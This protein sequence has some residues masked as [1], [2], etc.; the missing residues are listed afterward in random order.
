MGTVAA[1]DRHLPSL[2]RPPFV[3][4]LTVTFA[5]FVRPLNGTVMEVPFAVP[6]LFLLLFDAYCNFPVTL[7]GYFMVTLLQSYVTF[8]QFYLTHIYCMP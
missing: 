2:T 7:V 1:L 3:R 4:H 8:V 6:V 5:A